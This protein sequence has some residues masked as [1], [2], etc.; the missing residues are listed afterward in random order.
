M[1]TIRS[2]PVWSSQIQVKKKLKNNINQP[3]KICLFIYFQ[4]KKSKLEKF[5]EYI[6]ARV[7]IRISKS[8][9]GWKKKKIKNK[10]RNFDSHFTIMFVL[11][12]INT[13]H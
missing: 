6:K 5:I 9:N 8:I 2:T 4:I 13:I 12:L 1:L 3:L 11:S 10:K 7:G